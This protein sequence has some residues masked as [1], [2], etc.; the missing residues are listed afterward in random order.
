MSPRIFK[1]GVGRIP[2]VLYKD[3]PGDGKIYNIRG[4]GKEGGPAGRPAPMHRCDT[5]RAVSK[6]RGVSRERRQ[7]RERPRIDSKMV[8]QD[9]SG[10]AG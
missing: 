5:P 2:I 3:K 1:K 6:V 8:V 7:S 4:K 10:G 9:H